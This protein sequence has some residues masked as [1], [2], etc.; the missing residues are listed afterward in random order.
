MIDLR[1]LNAVTV[2]AST[3]RAIVGG[4]AVW[5]EVDA[6]TVPVGW[7][8]TGGHVSHTGVAGLTLG[9]GVGHLMRRFGLTADSLIS[10]ELV[11]ADS[12]LL[13]VSKDEHPDLF[14]AL[15]GAGANYGIVTKFEFQLREFSGTVFGGMVFYKPEDGPQLMRLYREF[16]A[17]APDS[18]TTILGYLH[19][20]PAPFVPEALRFKPGYAIVV[21]GTDQPDAERGL[22]EL[23]SFGPPLFDAL[24]AIPY[25][26][27]QQMLD[28]AMPWGTRCYLKS[29][30]IN[31]YSDGVLDAI[32]AT[33]PKMPP[34]PSQALVIQM[35]GAVARVPEAA[36]AFG[37]RSAAGLALFLG[38]WE[39]E[40][41]RLACRDWARSS[42]DALEPY[43]SGTYVN[44]ADEEPE[45]RLKAS[46]GAEKYTKL[47][48][49]K[50]QYDPDNVFRLN[51][52]IKPGGPP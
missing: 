52:N 49:L 17:R 38:V 28:P 2:D 22:K 26:L 25:G 29:H 19:A 13:R 50:R 20:P 7:V 47:S 18:I 4:G 11:T 41:Q 10:A 34:G 44:L 9:G 24:G 40:S 45:E 31:S 21:A 33:T 36:T 12:R 16:I 27:L 48:R 3:G 6:K 30:Y 1:R 43:A 32:H 23:R 42:S 37:G 14:W 15:R 51:Q 8:V 46:Y 5:A 35:G 39:H